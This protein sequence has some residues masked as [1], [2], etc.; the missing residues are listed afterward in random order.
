M[1]VLFC[2]CRLQDEYVSL[3]QELKSTIEESKLVQEKYKGLLDQV[4]REIGSKHVEN[5]ELRT[6]VMTDQ[7]LEI[8]KMQMQDEVEMPYRQKM[9]AVNEE[10]DQFRTEYNKLK[11]EYS[12]LKSVYEHDKQENAR[13]LDEMKMRHEAE[14]SNLRKEREMIIGR[15]QAEGPGDAQR[16]RVLQRENA[17]L[18]LKLKGLLTELEEIR[19]QRE[20]Q[21]LQS[22][23]VGRMQSKQLAEN[24]ANIKA[25]EVCGHITV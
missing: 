20:H 15:S 17:Q 25:L 10:L 21:G 14:V 18:H 22:D 4:R 5:E 1:T 19:A 2:C 6:Q 8:F 11:Y 24:Q 13:I 12:F 9:S 16:V 7:K 23:H 3:Q